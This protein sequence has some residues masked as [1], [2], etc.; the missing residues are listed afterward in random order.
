M[1]EP[2]LRRSGRRSRQQR[3]LRTGIGVVVVVAVIAIVGQFL[4]D[5]EPGDREPPTPQVDFVAEVVSRSDAGK[6]PADAASAEAEEIRLLLN[7]WYQRAFVD[8]KL[9]GD[10]TFP[11][12]AARFARDA[13]ASF[14]RDIASLTIGDARTEVLRV[15]PEKDQAQARITI[16]FEKARTPRFA[17]AAVV[18]RARASLREPGSFPLRIA[19]TATLHLQNTA[20]GW[21]VVYYSAKQ[22]QES[23]VPSPTPTPTAS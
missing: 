21:V 20:K 22:S 4:G 7:D 13:R 19:Q 6:P 1:R 17:V 23:V 3:L 16:F 11:E 10:G 15:E 18:F 12:V 9:Y 2:T 8:P 14:A 5:G